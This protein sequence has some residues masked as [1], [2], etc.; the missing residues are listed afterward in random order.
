MD[1]P[2]LYD[3]PAALQ[4]Q[5]RH[6]K[7]RSKKQAATIVDLEEKNVD[8]EAKVAYLQEALAQER[9]WRLSVPL[10]H[11][12][13]ISGKPRASSLHSDV[14]PFPPPRHEESALK[15]SAS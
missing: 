8:L 9:R 12:S 1:L 3:A 10:V 14:K 6:Y 13:Q 5:V 7:A 2:D 4:P 15:V 11:E